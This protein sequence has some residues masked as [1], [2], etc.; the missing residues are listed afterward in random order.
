VL[1]ASEPQGQ[2]TPHGRRARGSSPDSRLCSPVCISSQLQVCSSRYSRMHQGFLH[3]FLYIHTLF[4]PYG[5]PTLHTKSSRPIAALS[6]ACPTLLQLR[7][8]RRPCGG[9]ATIR[10]DAAVWLAASAHKEGGRPP[11]GAVPTALRLLFGWGSHHLI[12]RAGGGE[13]APRARESPA[14]SAG[15]LSPVRSRPSI[16]PVRAEE[17]VAAPSL[18]AKGVVPSPP[19]GGM[20]SS[21]RVM[22]GSACATG[23]CGG[24]RGLSWPGQARPTGGVSACERPCHCHCQ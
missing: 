7:I 16:Q 3:V 5:R 15:S 12:S 4:F 14:P 2:N 20:F 17:T 9:E 13:A 6:A 1:C 23:P 11:I 10:P 18:P 21:R 8:A 19:L 22:M 24:G